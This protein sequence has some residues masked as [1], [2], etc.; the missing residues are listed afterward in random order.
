MQI[1]LPLRPNAVNDMVLIELQG[2]LECDDDAFAGQT[3]GEI[4]WGDEAVRKPSLVIGNH[5][6]EGRLVALPK[7]IA[8]LKRGS[9]TSTVFPAVWMPP[10][11]AQEEDDR[12]EWHVVGIARSKYLFKTRPQNIV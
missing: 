3:L 4:S 12:R 5:R 10:T 8:V 11:A 9:T 2:T 7:P 1:F 6:L